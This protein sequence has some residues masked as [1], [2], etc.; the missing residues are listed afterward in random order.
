MTNAFS[1]TATPA[2]ATATKPLP[3]P[4][5]PSIPAPGHSPTSSATPESGKHSCQAIGAQ[6]S[7]S[8]DCNT[9]GAHVVATIA[10]VWLMTTLVCSHIACTC[11]TRMSSCPLIEG[12][13][14]HGADAA[15]GESKSANGIRD[16]DSTCCPIQFETRGTLDCAAAT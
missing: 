2:Y 15:R 8:S 10:Q 14:L 13:P 5:V 16:S 3:M 11:L 7:E 9:S 4:V 6:Y 1:N 12:K